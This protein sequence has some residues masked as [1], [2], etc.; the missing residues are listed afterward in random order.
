MLNVLGISIT[1]IPS[2]MLCGHCQL[3]YLAKKGIINYKFVPE[4]FLDNKIVEWADVLVFIRSDSDLEAYVSKIAKKAG[5]R[6]I[7]VLDDDLLNVPSYASSYYYYS[8]PSTHKNMK[9][10]MSNCDMFLTPSPV[11]MEKYGGP[12]K[13][14]HL[15][16]E[17]SLNRIVEKPKNDKVKIGFAGSIDRAKDIADILEETIR[18]LIDK[19]QDKIS[20]E[21][22]GAHPSFIDELNI[23]YLPYQDGYDAYTAYMAKCNWDIGLAPMP[24]S[25]FHECKYFNKFVEYASFGIVGVYSN[26]KPYIFGIENGVNGLLVEN[27]TDDWF[28]AICKLVDDSLY[29]EKLSRECIRQANEIYNLEILA[30]DY[31]EKIKKDYIPD[32]SAKFHSFNIVKKTFTL[33]R[34]YRKIIEKK[35]E[36]PKWL[37][38]KLEDR[39]KL[40]KERAELVNNTAKL[41]EIIKNKDTV[42]IISPYV[43]G[44]PDNSYVARVK[45][46]DELLNDFNVVYIDGEDKAFDSVRTVFVDER[47][48][49]IKFNSFVRTQCNEVV[50][51][52]EDGKAC[53]IHNVERFIPERLGT[54]FY[55]LLDDKKILKIWDVHDN[56][57]EKYHEA[58]NFHTEM[59]V[60]KIEKDFVDKCDLIISGRE[61]VLFNIQAKYKRT[62]AC[63]IVNKETKNLAELIRRQHG[64]HIKQ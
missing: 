35:L 5:K 4:H 48:A 46:I 11:L 28:D 1:F 25:D 56:F 9:T 27:N 3:D 51:M 15:I 20:V 33:K 29:R 49:V 6:L 13:Y 40:R 61:G 50:A 10:V 41:K 23:K 26:V 63:Y 64:R 43:L 7:Y 59:V 8:L 32:R 62:N 55:A 45:E 30:Y 16:K 36:F 24:V 57:P 18:K 60:E 34:I 12:F 17:P 53:L 47:T 31:L 22:M 42:F 54:D 14:K 19:Y 2:V 52:L 44:Y 38:A 39:K 58:M 21:F 37:I